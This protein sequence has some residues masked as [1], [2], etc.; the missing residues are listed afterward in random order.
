MINAV[1]REIPVKLAGYSKVIPFNGAFKYIVEGHSFEMR[2]PFRTVTGRRKVVASLKEAIRLTGLRDGMTVSFHHHL[3]NGDYVTNL[4]FETIRE[5]GIKDLK[6]AHSAIF[7]IHEPLLRHIQDSVIT[8][9]ET[10]WIGNGIGAKLFS[11]LTSETL[12]LAEPIKLL[13]HGGRARRI[14]SGDTRIDVAFIAAPSADDYGNINGVDGPSACGSLGYAFPDSENADQVVAVTDN[15]VPYPLPYISIDQTHVDYVVEVKKIGEPAGIESGATKRRSSPINDIIAYY[16]AK[17]IDASGL[18]LNDVSFQTGTGGIALATTQHLRKIM[19]SRNLVGSFGLGGITRDFVELLQEG[20]LRTLLDVQCFD[21]ESIHSLKESPNHIEIGASM[22]AN[23]HSR[24]CAVNKLDI[25]VLS[26][27]EI[28]V[29]FNVNVTTSSEG[30]IMGG[31][32]G[33]SDS[34]AGSQLC[35]I[36]APMMRERIPIVVDTVTTITTPGETVDVLVTERGVAVNPRR[37][38]LLGKIKEAGLPVVGIEELRDI[39][40]KNCGR[41]KKLAFTDRII[42]VQEYR[43]GTVI[44]VVRQTK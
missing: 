9:I 43:D 12:H 14:E 8:R 15:L 39:T 16:A 26:A 22:Y 41:P 24:G 36:T 13:T 10:D 31:S 21:Q 44:D 2:R 18:L 38:E 19:A 6:L 5:L 34:S 27:V 30:I 33:H 42:A 4:V 25:S 40:Y 32:G 1:G 37:P 20:R 28:D 23:P 11:G 29:N 17:V 35:V 3:R 7:D